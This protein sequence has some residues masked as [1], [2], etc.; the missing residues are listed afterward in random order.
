[1]ITVEMGCRKC[2]PIG[3]NI[4]RL[5]SFFIIFALLIVIMVVSTLRTATKKKSKLTV[6]MR[7]LMNYL[8]VLVLAANFNINYPQLFLDFIRIADFVSS[9]A[10]SFLSID[11]F[12]KAEFDS[13]SITRIHNLKL[14]IMSTL[15]IILSIISTI[16]WLVICLIKKRFKNYFLQRNLATILI[17]FFLAYPNLVKSL[18]FHF[19]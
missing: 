11:C 1:M 4:F 6:Y 14:I 2:P 8:Q 10:T 18:M 19:K 3:L 5:L 13:D 9:P 12:L 16:C 17:L 15:P 7:I